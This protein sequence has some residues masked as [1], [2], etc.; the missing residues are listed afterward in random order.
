MKPILVF[1]LV[2]VSLTSQGQNKLSPSA[3]FFQA[4]LQPLMH[5]KTGEL[6]EM[7]RHLVETYDLYTDKGNWYIG[8][9]LLMTESGQRSFLESKGV[10]V[11]VEMDRIYSVRIPVQYFKTVMELDEVL[12]IEAASQVEPELERSR[13]SVRADSVHAGAGGLN[14]PYTGKGVIIAI[15]DWGFDYTHPV[16]FDSTGQLRISRAWDQNK[17]S[18]PAP[19]G[20]NFGTEYVGQDALMAAKEDTL[21]VFGPGSHG[22]HVGGIAGGTGAGTKHKGI[23]PGAELIFIS[24]KRDDPSFVD[25]ISYVSRYADAVN[26]PFVVNMSFGGHND[27]H[28]GSTLRNWALD[29][30]AGKGKVFVASAGNN[31]GNQFH[32]REDFET[33]DTLL[34]EITFNTGLDD[35]WGETVSAWAEPGKSFSISLMLANSQNQVVFESAVY[36]TKDHSST[37]DTIYANAGDTLILRL[38]TEDNNTLNGKP[39]MLLE[40]RKL[41]TKKL[42]LKV[43]GSGKTHF[44]HVNRLNARVTNW[45]QKFGS[46][47][48]GCVLGNDEYGIGGPQAI[49]KEVITVAAHRGEYPAPGGGENGGQ[50]SS[51][52]SKGPTAD[53]RRKPDI[54][55]PGQD[56]CSSVNSYDPNPGPVVETITKDGRDYTFVRYSGTSMS[57]P[58]V[59]G[60]VALML[61]A[62]PNLTAREVKD[63]LR[64]TARLDIHTGTI[65]GE[66]DLLWGWGKADALAAVKMAE[67]KLGN[68]EFTEVPS[69]YWYPNPVTERKIHLESQEDLVV[70]VYDMQGK[71][72]MT[73]EVKAGTNELDLGT[74]SPGIYV[75]E[76][77]AGQRSGFD[78]LIVP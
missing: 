12:Y 16:F 76:W 9:L 49:S 60:V 50:L 73:S 46:S 32:I 56:V 7:N 5:P 51:F 30:L 13:Y 43:A 35:Y 68:R 28:D 11:N 55:G 40:V 4:E 17:N 58:A 72:V 77:S 39:N 38:V 36:A 19:N 78:K 26:K 54:S 22:T 31:G 14:M 29:I 15:I 70:T 52:S 2:L 63:I 23:A 57:G 64:I 62:N 45:G 18:G 42:I 25:A 8:A 3:R 27:P 21:Y 20:F 61:E 1:C 65:S 6:L 74:L 37:D 66:S 41:G 67:L 69:L 24:L 48:P 10:V 75:L 59:A 44:W 34:T 53:E 71:K 33:K 47:F